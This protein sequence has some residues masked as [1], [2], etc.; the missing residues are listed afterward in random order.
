MAQVYVSTETSAPTAQLLTVAPLAAEVEGLE[1]EA[2]EA[3]AP[4]EP[5]N[6]LQA[7]QRHLA[8]VSNP[9]A[10]E[11]ALEVSRDALLTMLS[12]GYEPELRL[13]I[14]QSLLS[15]IDVAYHGL[16]AGHLETI[17]AEAEDFGMED[18]ERQAARLLQQLEPSEE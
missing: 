16:L 11:A 4:A 5:E 7:M 3:E 18:V 8:V 14:V 13:E 6:D 2:P 15:G 10:P 12:G 9:S 17:R 1:T